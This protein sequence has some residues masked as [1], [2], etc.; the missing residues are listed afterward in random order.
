MKQHTSATNRV[1]PSLKEHAALKAS[2]RSVSLPL[3][4]TVMVYADGNVIPSVLT[5]VNVIVRNVVEGNGSDRY[6]N[7]SNVTD[8]F[9][10]RGQISIDRY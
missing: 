2:I 10:Q 7:G 8:T 1:S 3:F 6:I 4:G 5:I 9:L